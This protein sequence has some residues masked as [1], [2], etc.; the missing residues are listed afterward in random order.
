M[1]HSILLP[2][3]VKTVMTLLRKEEKPYIH[4]LR[5]I[6]LLEV[7]IQAISS[8]QWAQKMSRNS[9]KHQIISNSQYGGRKGRQAQSA[10]L[11]KILYYDINNRYVKDYTIIDEDL[12]ANYDRELCT[13]SALEARKAGAPCSAGVFMND[14]IKAQQFHVKTKYGVSNSSFGYKADDPIWGLGQ[15]L[16][17]SGESWKA[18]SSTIDQCMKEKCSGMKFTSPDSTVM[19]SKLMDLYI[20]DSAQGYNYADDGKTLLEQTEHNLQLNAQLVYATGGQLALDKCKYYDVRHKFEKGI[21][22]FLHKN[23]YESVL[24]VQKDF[25]SDKE[26]IKL[27]NFDETHKTLGYYVCPSGNQANN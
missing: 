16:A 10:V 7:E 14:F 1:Q 12:K 3:L 21:P 15:G 5:P 20:D 17:W 4:R 22:R 6:L 13:L 25:Q 2:R 19:V 8:S 24:S 9:E 23:E 18:A 11:N 26:L 27:L